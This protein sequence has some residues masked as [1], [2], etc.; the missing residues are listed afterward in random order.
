MNGTA[1]VMI[2]VRLVIKKWSLSKAILSNLNLVGLR[3]VGT[4]SLA[5]YWRVSHE[6]KIY[7]LV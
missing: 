2:A 1:P 5:I 6:Q 7:R 3:S 4:W